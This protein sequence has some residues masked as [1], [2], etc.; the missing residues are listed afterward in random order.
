MVNRA[1]Q[2]AYRRLLMGIV[3]AF[4][5]QLGVIP[6]VA[7][8][9]TDTRLVYS[10]GAPNW[11]RAVGRLQVPGSKYSEGRRRHHRE[12]CS[13]TLV[14]RRATQKSHT[15][16]TAWHCL[17]FYNDVSKP[18]IFT[19]PSDSGTELV[20][21]AYRVADGGGMGADWAILHL[22][23]AVSQ[24]AASAVLIADGRADPVRS[25][26][27]AGFSRD[28]GKG[29][30]GKQLTF[31]AN[32]RITGQQRATSDSNCWAFKGAS[33][34][35]VVQVSAAGTPVLSGVIS[36]GDGAGLSTYVPV[37]AFRSAINRHVK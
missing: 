22:F 12:D 11:L 26:A 27:M 6:P 1:E 21:E 7:R 32:C 37:N 8:A 17:E 9:D 34:G 28:S 3:V 23:H 14:S 2:G 4:T 29:A 25:I 13:A 35:A 15:I 33:G 24:D 18:I 16:V 5:C 31:D 36:Q 19:L 20:R 30:D 10:R